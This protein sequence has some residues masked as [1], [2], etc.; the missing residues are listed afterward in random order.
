[1]DKPLVSLLVPVYNVEKYLRECL[2]SLINQTLKNIEIIL[3]ND[4]STD[5]SR[6][7][8]EEYCVLDARIRLINQE[9]G[10][11]GHARNVLLPHAQGKYVIFIDSDDYIDLKTAAVLYEKAEQDKTDVLIYNGKAFFDYDGR[12]VFEQRNYFNL[13]EKDAGPV[14]SGLEMMARTM[15]IANNAFKLYNRRFLLDNGLRYPEGVYGE[16]VEFFYRL[17][18][19][20]QRVS[21]INFIGYYRRYRVGSIMTEGSIKNVRDRIVN[22][23]ALA[24]LLNRIDDRAYKEAAAKQMAFYACGLWTLAMCRQNKDER[25]QLLTDFYRHELNVFIARHKKG[26][27]QA[28]ASLL[29]SLP[30]SLNCVKVL[31]CVIIKKVFQSRSRLFM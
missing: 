29:I 18:I 21:Y 26:F 12:I 22:F 25:K 8:A 16:D 13:D 31:A 28:I 15:S 4:G 23:P 3:V 1:M 27:A 7:I 19:I 6:A 10:G 14:L 20:A 5:G 17:M 30:A 9:N 11:L 2:D 24:D